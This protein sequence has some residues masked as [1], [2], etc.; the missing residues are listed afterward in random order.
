VK[1]GGDDYNAV[2]PFSYDMGGIAS[3][4]VLL[5]LNTLQYIDLTKPWWGKSVRDFSILNKT[6]F[7]LSDF[8]L[9]DKENVSI[10]M[11]KIVVFCSVMYISIIFYNVH[12][13]I[14]RLYFYAVRFVYV[15]RVLKSDL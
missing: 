3:K 5:D 9:T 14:V 8:I 4:G 6:Y 7:A 12:T 10:M 2:I 11:Y 13:V 1:A 15:F